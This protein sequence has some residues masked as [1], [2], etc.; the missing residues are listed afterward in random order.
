MSPLFPTIVSSLLCSVSFAK[1]LFGATLQPDALVFNALRHMCWIQLPCNSLY[2]NPPDALF[3]LYSGRFAIATS[4]NWPVV[5]CVT[6]FRLLPL[7]HPR[8]PPQLHSCPAL[9]T[10]HPHQLSRKLLRQLQATHP[11]LRS[12][13]LLKLHSYSRCPNHSSSQSQAQVNKHSIFQT[14]QTGLAGG[15]GWKL[16]LTVAL[17]RAFHHQ[18]QHLPLTL[19]ISLPA[20]PCRRA[21]QRLCL[22]A[23]WLRL[24]FRDHLLDN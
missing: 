11:G 13:Q 18:T 5:L 4:W 17:H 15:A 14:L 9:M 2:W 3:L 16:P 6:C 22:K 7:P 21:L 8:M 19:P 10:H 12:S 24:I 20:T 1:G 23:T